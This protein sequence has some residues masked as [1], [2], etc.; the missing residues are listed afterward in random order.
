MTIDIIAPPYLCG[1][2]DGSGFV[3]IDDVIFLIDYIFSDGPAP[4]PLE[5]GDV[6]CSEAIDI[7]DVV[8]L[9]A[10]IFASGPAPCA[11]CP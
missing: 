10:Y 11:D 5:S 9:I 3:D 1:D 7:D 4:E 8:Y 6:D 2:A